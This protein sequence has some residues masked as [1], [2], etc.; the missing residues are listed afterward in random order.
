MEQLQQLEQSYSRLSLKLEHYKQ[1]V[2]EQE[3]KI[4]DLRVEVTGLLNRLEDYENAPKQAEETVD[5]E[6]VD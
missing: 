5:A 6:L 3:E 2:T 1:K 4:A